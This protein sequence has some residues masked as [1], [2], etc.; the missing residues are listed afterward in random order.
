MCREEVIAALCEAE[1]NG[2]TP[3]IHG[4]LNMK[5]QV[6][7]DQNVYTHDNTILNSWH[8]WQRVQLGVDAQAEALKQQP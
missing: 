4:K 6:G 1:G 3:D 2:K 8:Y 7:S 5:P